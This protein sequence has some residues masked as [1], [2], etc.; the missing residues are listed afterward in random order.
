MIQFR[1][2]RNSLAGVPSSI[3]DDYAK[4]LAY[5]STV[6]TLPEFASAALSCSHIDED[7]LPFVC[8]S[9][10]NT[11]IYHFYDKDLQRYTALGSVK[12]IQN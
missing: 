10:H 2:L 5:I 9:G 4:F 6:R 7:C 11:Y 3:I 12:F 1:F 8:A